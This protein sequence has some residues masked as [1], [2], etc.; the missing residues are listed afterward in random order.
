MVPHGDKNYYAMRP[1]IA[2]P[3]P[4][5]NI[6]KEDAVVDLD[7]YFG[8]HPML[9]P[10]QPLW[11]GNHLAIVQA[12]GSPDPT[13]SHFDAQDYMESGTPGVKAT[14]DG[15]LNRALVRE[16]GKTAPLRAVALGPTLPRIFAG[17]ERSRGGGLGE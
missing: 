9:A 8:L 2:I 16:P 11:D 12:V 4:A 3:R 7:G 15:W 17:N 13:R 10:L 5:A 6:A 1:T 14:S